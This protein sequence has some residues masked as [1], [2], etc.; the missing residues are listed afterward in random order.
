[1]L[2]HLI[3]DVTLIKDDA[4]IGVGVRLRGGATRRL[5]LPA[6]LSVTD[7]YRT[8]PEVIALVDRMLTGHSY[9]EI[10]AALNQHGVR[11]TRGNAFDAEKIS[12]LRR[13]FGLKT[14]YRRLRDQGLL[15]RQEVEAML[16]V[17]AAQVNSLRRNGLL[18]GAHAGSSLW[19]YHAPA[20]P[21]RLRSIISRQGA[22]ATGGRGSD[23]G[24]ST[25][26]FG[27][28]SSGGPK[29]R[30]RRST[31]RRPTWLRR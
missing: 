17:D 14:R 16:D 12:A 7:R 20:D 15:T 18:Q 23:E 10:A 21:D 2:A 11:T 6:P 9:A 4:G 30:P 24:S 31:S 29:N 8:G 3:A 26:C 1:M 22:S 19:L 25:R 27:M 5:S 28:A 13:D